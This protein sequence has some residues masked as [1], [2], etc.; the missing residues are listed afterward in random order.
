MRFLRA[1]AALVNTDKS[2]FVKRLIVA[3]RKMSANSLLAGIAAA[4]TT[5]Y[6]LRRAGLEFADW[7]VSP[8]ATIANVLEK[9]YTPRVIGFYEQILGGRAADMMDA[10][11]IQD[12]CGH[13]DYLVTGKPDAAVRLPAC[14]A[15]RDYVR[16]AVVREHPDAGL[17]PATM[18]DQFLDYAIDEAA[19][20]FLR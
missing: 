3:R 15:I 14:A 6:A 10:K 19:H 5:Q 7:M 16:F 2:A 20:V 11:L 4:G 17:S 8:E 18:T 13:V 1:A 12:L 9:L